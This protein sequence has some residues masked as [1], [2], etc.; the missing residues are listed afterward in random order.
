MGGVGGTR[1]RELDDGE[2]EAMSIGCRKH[3]G[4]AFD[5]EQRVFEG[6]RGGKRTNTA[7]VLYFVA[8]VKSLFSKCRIAEVH[9]PK[10]SNF[11]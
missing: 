5:D 8:N 11:A 9:R 10:K 7:H 2:L 3:E 4:R 1:E 6:H